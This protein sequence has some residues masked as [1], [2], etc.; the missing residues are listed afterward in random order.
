[1]AQRQEGLWPLEG[2]SCSGRQTSTQLRFSEIAGEHNAGDRDQEG[3]SDHEL[4]D[5]RIVLP[6]LNP[7]QGVW[8]RTSSM[9]ANGE[10]ERWGKEGGKEGG[11]E[12]EK[13]INKNA[14]HFTSSTLL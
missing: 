13:G 11:R 3:G 14:P 1:M 5:G 6:I 12:E 10:R 9:H 4:L 8:H 2:T 7:W